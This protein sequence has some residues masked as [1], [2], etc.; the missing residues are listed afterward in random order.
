MAV[1]MP[2]ASVE[3]EDVTEPLLVDQDTVRPETADPFSVTLTRNGLGSALATTAVWPSPLGVAALVMATIGLPP[4]PPP[5]PPGSVL[6]HPATNTV[7][8][9]VATTTNGEADIFPSGWQAKT[10]TR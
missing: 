6:L 5:A 3:E 10:A 7:T 8:T 4:P 1:A 2:E 9:A